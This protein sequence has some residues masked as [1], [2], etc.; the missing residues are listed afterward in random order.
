VQDVHH[1]PSI[2][3]KL[4]KLWPKQAILHDFRFLI[5][6]DSSDKWSYF[7]A[8]VC[9]PSHVKMFLLRI[10]E[11]QS[12]EPERTACVSQ[13]TGFFNENIFENPTATTRILASTKAL[14]FHNLYV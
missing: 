12:E 7:S 14:L 11:F 1:S 13:K 10:L 2:D 3:P 4:D 9:I 6:L 5:L 8:A